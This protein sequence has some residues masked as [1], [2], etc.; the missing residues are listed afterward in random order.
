MSKLNLPWACIGDFNEIA[1]FNKKDGRP[2]RPWKQISSFQKVI[3]ECQ[4]IDSGWTGLDQNLLGVMDIGMSLG[5]G[6]D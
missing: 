6:C 1:A 3:S 2:R 4:F 5:P